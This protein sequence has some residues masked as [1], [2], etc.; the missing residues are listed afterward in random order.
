LRT[1]CKNE[2]LGMFQP[3][4]SKRE[5]TD[6]RYNKMNRRVAQ[7]AQLD[8]TVSRLADRAFA[9]QGQHSRC[10]R[11]QSLACV[12]AV[13]LETVLWSALAAPS[14]PQCVVMYWTAPRRRLHHGLLSG[15]CELG[16]WSCKP[17]IGSGS[18]QPSLA[19]TQLQQKIVQSLPVQAGVEANLS[20]SV[21]TYQT[22]AALLSHAHAVQLDDNRCMEGTSV[23]A[24]GQ[25]TCGTVT[26]G[27]C[28]VGTTFF[29]TVLRGWRTCCCRCAKPKPKVG[30]ADASPAPGVLP[31]LDWWSGQ[32]GTCSHG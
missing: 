32:R 5:R 14:D 2:H 22:A 19:A 7:D 13:I 16:L 12:I 24:T 10:M 29:N 4:H 11:V 28:K 18:P 23:Q 3:L 6:F 1:A 17:S 31:P 30:L 26:G 21:I 20:V 8:S 15:G 9:V 25:P 27:W